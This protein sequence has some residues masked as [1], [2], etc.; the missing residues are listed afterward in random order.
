MVAAAALQNLVTGGWGEILSASA[1]AG[2]LTVFDFQLS[3]SVPY[4]FW[5]GLIG[6]GFLTMGS[7]GTDQLIVQRLLTCKDLS[8]SRKAL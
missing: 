4:T 7:H 1:E 6:G 5:A 3:L 2:K 8:S